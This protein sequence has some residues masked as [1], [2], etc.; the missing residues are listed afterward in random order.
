M[1]VEDAANA[2]DEVVVKSFAVDVPKTRN[3]VGF[4]LVDAVTRSPE[5]RKTT[6]NGIGNVE[7]DINYNELMVFLLVS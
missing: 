5:A 3:S 7:S 6:S 4:A 1:L 2:V